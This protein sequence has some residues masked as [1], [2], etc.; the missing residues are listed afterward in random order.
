LKKKKELTKEEQEYNEV[1]KNFEEIGYK[2]D[3]I[4]RC[5]RAA[6][7]DPNRAYDYLTSG[8]PSH[9]EKQLEQQE[10]MKTQQTEN[11]VDEKKKLETIN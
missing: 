9:V 8:I 1:I 4:V 11:K 10:K 6:F 3:M 2:R 5:L 7:G